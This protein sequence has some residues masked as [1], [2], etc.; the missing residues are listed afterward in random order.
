MKNNP[1]LTD[2]EKALI[3][4]LIEK[5]IRGWRWAIDTDKGEP[6]IF[7][8]KI[9]NAKIILKK[10]KGTHKPEP[11]PEPKPDHSKNNKPLAFKADNPP[12]LKTFKQSFLWNGRPPPQGWVSVFFF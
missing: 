5:K 8:K 10:L 11:K 6:A 1:E 4:G 12:S 7:E 3:I 9:E 2:I